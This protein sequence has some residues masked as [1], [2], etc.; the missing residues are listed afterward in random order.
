[1]VLSK[2]E[3]LIAICVAAAILILLL[4]HFVI[5][6][7]RTERTRIATESAKA[8]ADLDDAKILF[9]REARLKRI[10]AEMQNGGLKVDAS[11]AESLTLNALLEWSTNSR[12]LL[13]AIRRERPAP[14]G[15]FQV[16]GFD[17]SG[18]GSMPEVSRLLWAIETASIPVRIN[19]MQITSQK[20]GTDNLQVRLSV[21]ALCLPPAKDNN[22]ASAG[23]SG[24]GSQ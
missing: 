19:E 4:N 23:S 3:R 17:V 10:W 7:Y 8:K 5:D 9:A 6:P 11:D 14:E 13:P 16:I 12:V 20:E 18:T 21:S 2:R 24:G 22:L 15:K 1:V